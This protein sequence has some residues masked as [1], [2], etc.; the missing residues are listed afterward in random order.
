MIYVNSTKEEN[1]KSNSCHQ[2]VTEAGCRSCSWL[3][4]C[5]VRSDVLTG[6]LQTNKM[7][8]C[9]GKINV[10]CALSAGCTWVFGG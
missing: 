3:G 8:V 2:R 9:F 1:V 4:T 10:H 7:L 6:R 5:L